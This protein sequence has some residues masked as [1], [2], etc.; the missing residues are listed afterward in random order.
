MAFNNISNRS[1][2]IMN[3][4]ELASA[5][6]QIVNAGTSIST[7]TD[8][9]DTN[10]SDIISLQ[11]LVNTKQDSFSE[12][13]ISTI[14]GLQTQLTNVGTSIS[15]LTDLIDT[16][17]SDIITLQNQGG[18]GISYNS[19]LSVGGLLVGMGQLV[20][21]T[22]GVVEISNS[23]I[24]NG[25]NVMNSLS[26]LQDSITSNISSVTSLNANY[27][28]LFGNLSVLQT[29]FTISQVKYAFAVTSNLNTT[30]TM[31]L[32]SVLPFNHISPGLCFVVPDTSAY[33]LS[34]YSYTIPKS[35]IWKINYQAFFN[36][37]PAVTTRIGIFRNNTELLMR[38]GSKT[39]YSE[40]GSL[41]YLLS[42][43]DVINCKV[44]D[45]PTVQMFFGEAR[46][47]FFGE[48]LS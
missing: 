3:E 27:A 34:T 43:G 1:R 16:N 39:S 29:D 7:L 25:T 45:T 28:T 26:S 48:L 22:E 36:S 32:G 8:M 17:I 23:L 40:T 19:P 6:E 37:G 13:P 31:G 47:L 11:T 18:S 2:G 20:S 33:N 41:M 42:Q 12:L 24:V 46:C 15:T 14:T 38:M 4:G 21:P 9:I 44:D 35:G 5:Q 30:L 10:T